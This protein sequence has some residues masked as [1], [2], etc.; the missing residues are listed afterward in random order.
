M[1][2]LTFELEHWLSRWLKHV[3]LRPRLNT[4]VDD[5]GRAVGQPGSLPVCDGRRVCMSEPVCECTS[6]HCRQRFGC[7][8]PRRSFARLFAF[9]VSIHRLHVQHL[10]S[11][12][13][14]DGRLFS[15]VRQLG[16]AA[17][18]I[19]RH[20]LHSDREWALC[21]CSLQRAT[22]VCLHR[23]WRYTCMHFCN[24]VRCDEVATPCYVSVSVSFSRRLEH[25][26]S[27][28]IRLGSSHLVPG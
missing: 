15:S 8:F 6:R 17:N 22:T 2:A 23:A 1:F 7:S 11:K 4:Y 9:Q 12:I 19:Q 14:M 16:R 5:F 20:G 3:V 21:A 13:S 25:A 10:Q 28:S 18:T 26:Q 24:T 27:T